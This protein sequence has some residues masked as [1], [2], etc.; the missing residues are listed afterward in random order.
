MAGQILSTHNIY[1][2]VYRQ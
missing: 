1:S 2:E